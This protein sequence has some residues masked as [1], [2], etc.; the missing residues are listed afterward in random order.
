MDA[1]FS[2]VFSGDRA[3]Y[4]PAKFLYSTLQTLPLMNNRMHMIF[5]F[6]CL[7]ESIRRWRRLGVSHIVKVS[8]RR[9]K[10]PS[11][12]KPRKC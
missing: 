1:M 9:S 12:G 3:P 2:F 7:M 11:L 6:P 8:E 10:N 4:S 5:S